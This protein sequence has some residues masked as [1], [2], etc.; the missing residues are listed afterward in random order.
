MKRIKAKQKKK[1][2]KKE[3]VKKSDTLSKEDLSQIRILGLETAN[4][5]SEMAT[6]EQRLVNLLQEQK[7]LAINIEKQK[8]L[9][10]Q[11]HLIYKNWKMKNDMFAQSLQE[12]YNF[13]IKD[14]DGYNPDTGDIIKE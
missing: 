9:L 13:S 11:K 1:V 8:N 2:V 12:R 6:E 5:K 14:G 3:E 7:I 4:A 10:K